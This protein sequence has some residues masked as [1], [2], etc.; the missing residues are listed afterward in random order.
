MP[1]RPKEMKEMK[2]VNEL[3]TIVLPAASLVSGALTL[4]L[5]T[6]VVLP[7]CGGR[8]QSPSA[9]PGSP[10]AS[11]TPSSSLSRPTATAQTGE[12]TPVQQEPGEEK[13]IMLTA[14]P[15]PAPSFPDLP[16]LAPPAD[17]WIAFETPE[18]QLALISPDGSRYVPVIKEGKVQSFAWSP[19]GRLLAFV[20]GGQLTIL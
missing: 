2:R 12:P 4:L 14:E 5:A 1:A 16:D 19:D 7:G 8:H 6:T 17:G 20:Q 11:P 15:T 10:T 9:L 3:P 18:E 13:Q